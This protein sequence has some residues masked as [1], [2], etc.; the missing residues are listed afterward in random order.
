MREMSE[1]LCEV[2][3]A[4]ECFVY[5]YV[6]RSPDPEDRRAGFSDI[7]RRIHCDQSPRS[8]IGRI[9]LHMGDRAAELLEKR[10]RIFSLWRPLLPV[11]EAY[12]LAACTYTSTTRE[13]LVPI[14]VVYPHYAEE[15]FEIRHRLMHQWF[16]KSAMTPA[17]IM[18]IKLF[19]NQMLGEGDTAYYSPHGSWRDPNARKNAPFRR[20]IELRCMVFG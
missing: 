7:T 4:A 18:L 8:A 6:R 20:S 19:D 16:Y 9:K 13:D 17:D 1:Y 15:S 2:L 14:D 10:C 3:G 11:I 5:D 12:P